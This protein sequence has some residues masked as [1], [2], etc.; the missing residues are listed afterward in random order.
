MKVNL[1]SKCIG[2]KTFSDWVKSSAIGKCDFDESHGG[3]NK[4]VSVESLAIEVDRHFR[5]N[6]Q[7][8]GE[9]TFLIYFSQIEEKEEDVILLL[10][11]PG[12]N[13]HAKAQEDFLRFINEKLA[14]KHQVIY[15][16]HSPFLVPTDGWHTVRTVEDMEDEGT[17]ISA[18]ALKNNKDTVFPLQ[19]A[20]G[21]DIAQTLFVGKNCLLVE[22]PSDLIYLQLMSNLLEEKGRVILDERWVITPVGGA[23]KIATFIAL[24]KSNK[25][26]IAV[27][28]DFAKKDRQKIENLT[29]NGFLKNK[30]IVLLNQY[31]D[32]KE[33]DIEDLFS[34]ELYLQIVNDCYKNKLKKEVKTT[35]LSKMPRLVKRFEK[36]FEGSDFID[37][38]FNHYKP[39]IFLQSNFDQYKDKID[40]EILGKFEEIFKKV[41]GLL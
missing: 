21:Y 13:L 37:G 11:E 26:N 41:N 16:T 19:G 7:V 20:L 22:G 36:I 39:S 23:D 35:D 15:S 24:L 10:D 17:K 3:N 33:A 30:N 28:R 2:E 8:G 9:Y 1:C 5:E 31:N 40:D 18:D 12:L 27:L 6:Y 29:K 32:G 14:K 25:L 38:S 4:I 34:E